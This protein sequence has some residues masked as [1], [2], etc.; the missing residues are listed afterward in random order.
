LLIF[1]EA[2]NE[3]T[4][5]PSTEAYAA[6]NSIRKR[7]GLPD[8]ENLTKDEF[9]E[10]VLNERRLELCF[11]GH[12]WYDLVRTD[13]LVSTLQAKGI[14]NVQEYHKVFPVPQLEIDLN[15]TLKPQNDGYPE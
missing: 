4:G 14:T 8:L 3:V 13:R 2:S 7:A 9:R 11:E 10:A 15:Q 1:A 12:R 5:E 6:I